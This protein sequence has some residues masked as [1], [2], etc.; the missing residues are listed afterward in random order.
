M[1]K[2]YPSPHGLWAPSQS[3][4]LSPWS[5]LHS[6]PAWDWLCQGGP[7]S[8][9]LLS[10]L[11][12][13]NHPQVSAASQMPLPFIFFWLL[14]LLLTLVQLP[15][16]SPGPAFFLPSI[17]YSSQRQQDSL[18]IKTDRSVSPFPISFLSPLGLCTFFSFSLYKQHMYS[19]HIHTQ[20]QTHTSR[21]ALISYSLHW[22]RSGCWWLMSVPMDSVLV[23]S[24]VKDF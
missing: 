8:Q 11:C 13:V 15:L 18:L 16:P 12:V 6:N 5:V 3:L 9:S 24:V 21:L 2:R 1:A 14:L 19:W 23:V 17:I 4:P 22:S 10:L 20:K 7:L